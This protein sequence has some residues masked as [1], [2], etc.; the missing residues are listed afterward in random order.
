MT[1]REPFLSLE[2]RFLSVQ[3]VLADVRTCLEAASGS[4]KISILREGAAPLDLNL[5]CKCRWQI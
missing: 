3:L 5:I 2:V 1:W 4:K